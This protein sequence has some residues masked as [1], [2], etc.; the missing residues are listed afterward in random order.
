MK[1]W[2]WDGTY[3]DHKE[4]QAICELCGQSGLRYHFPI[5]N[6]VDDSVKYIGSECILKFDVSAKAKDG[7][8]LNRNEIRDK[9]NNTRNEISK[10]N[11][12]NH[13]L[14]VLRKL[15]AEEDD[16]KEMFKNFIS[17][18]MDNG[19][20]TPKQLA[21]LQ[22]KLSTHKV[23]HNKSHFALSIKKNIY[24]DQLREMERWKINKLMPYMSNS[25]KEWCNK[26]IE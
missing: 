6:S 9:I 8:L 14:T 4:P 2:F 10:Q 12:V 16:L 18:Y 3:I 21:T 23:D 5:I 20:F 17:Y 13:V 11:K 25:Q 19:Y 24:K 7:R 15:V 22:W 26:E 1:N